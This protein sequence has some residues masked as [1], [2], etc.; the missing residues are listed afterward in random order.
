MKKLTIC[1]AAACMLAAC[2]SNPKKILVYAKGGTT[3]NKDTKT[4]DVKDG[5][6]Q[7]EE[8]LEYNTADKITLQLKSS[9]ATAP[10]DI[11][12]NGLYIVNA[13]KND[14][15]IGS[16]QK[17][18]DPKLKQNVTTQEQLKQAIDSLQQLTEGKNISAANRNYFILPKTAARITANTDAI[19]VGPFHKMTAIEKKGDKD[20]EVYQFSSISEIR[21]KIVKLT[22]LTVA[23]P[24]Q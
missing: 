15:I 14:T 10:I 12:E 21:E 20:P 8:T 2:S 7:E 9:D 4:I 3:V 5:A 24:A 18:S 22:A 6:G 17:F 16:Y 13:K 19:I 1:V 11:A 23:T